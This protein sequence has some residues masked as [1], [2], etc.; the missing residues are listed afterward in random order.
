[1][2]EL[3][4]AVVDE[5]A[6]QGRTLVPEDLVWLAESAHRDGPGVPRD[7]LAAYAE[8]LADDRDVAFDVRGFLGSVDDRLTSD[9]AW[10]GAEVLYRVEDDRISRYPARWHD[11]LGGSTDIRKFVAFLQEEVPEFEDDLGRGGAGRGVPRQSLLD[12]VAAVGDLDRQEATAA[13]EKA[14]DRGEIVEDA[15]QHP[16]ASVYLA[17]EASDLRDEDL[18]H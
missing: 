15:D 6:H 8:R 18:E 3:T 1:M 17:E 14:R 4:E 9:Q 12:V 2:V 13:L 11:E 5:A 16:G 7:V 10:Q